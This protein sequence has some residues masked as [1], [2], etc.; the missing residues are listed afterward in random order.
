MLGLSQDAVWLMQDATGL[1]P[2]QGVRGLREFQNGG[3]SCEGISGIGGR[4]S[5]MVPERVIKSSE[6]K[7]RLPWLE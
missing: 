7:E 1:R 6:K 2:I 4:S 5:A 3:L